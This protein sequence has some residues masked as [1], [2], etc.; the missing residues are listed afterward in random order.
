MADAEKWLGDIGVLL[1]GCEYEISTPLFLMFWYKTGRSIY[2]Y[3]KIYSAKIDYACMFGSDTSEILQTLRS[4]RATSSLKSISQTHSGQF[5]LFP[6]RVWRTYLNIWIY[7]SRIFIRKVFQTY[8]VN[9]NIFV[10][11]FGSVLL[12]EYIRILICIKINK[13]VTLCFQGNNMCTSANLV[14]SLFCPDIRQHWRLSICIYFGSVWQILNQ[15]NLR[16]AGLSTWHERPAWQIGKI[17]LRDSQFFILF[18]FFNL[19]VFDWV[20]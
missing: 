18:C 20:G 3:S 12:N 16:R 11:S 13:N 7:L 14:N 9:T 4:W 19:L 8:F 2:F 15:Q 6:S 10:Y 1:C 17:R 5:F